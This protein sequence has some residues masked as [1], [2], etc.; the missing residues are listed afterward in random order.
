MPKIKQIGIALILQRM[1]LFRKSLVLVFTASVF[2][3][4]VEIFDNKNDKELETFY[5]SY[6]KGTTSVLTINT[7]GLFQKIA[8]DLF[9][10]DKENAQFE[11]LNNLQK[12][13][14]TSFDIAFFN[15]KPL[16]SIEILELQIRDSSFSVVRYPSDKPTEFLQ[17]HD[18]KNYRIDIEGLTYL[19][20]NQNSAPTKELVMTLK[21][22]FKVVK[23]QNQ[24]ASL[25]E[26]KH[27][28]FG[29]E[30]S[31]WKFNSLSGVWQFDFQHQKDRTFQIIESESN[32]LH[33]STEINGQAIQKMLTELKVKIP[34]PVEHIDFLSLN[35]FG[36]EF[37]SGEELKIVPR[38]Q[39]SINFDSEQ[40]RND[41]QTTFS[42]L[43]IEK[44]LRF[45]SER[46]SKSVI[47][48]NSTNNQIQLTDSKTS[49]L[50][51]GELKTLLNLSGNDW[52]KSMIL[53][54]P[55]YRK[56]QEMTESV[57]I[58]T[59]TQENQ[60]VLKIK[61]NNQNSIVGLLLKGM[62]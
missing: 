40:A 44:D 43:N 46:I 50:M 34:L 22:T 31:N 19:F 25:V 28:Q 6:P 2:V 52:R 30:I 53:S 59:Q 61:S 11:R 55:I 42:A 24:K 17:V 7:A 8:F 39:V 48:L 18:G 57:K 3:S 49:F 62:L 16:S 4:S 1:F 23:N 58:E 21:R 41:F 20:L 36:S 32:S 56:L 12:D 10:R 51:K 15:W 14:Q 37:I 26:S 38:I 33:V 45:K 60:T 47:L 54:A 35:Y 9:F 29:K 5:S 13:D 27:I